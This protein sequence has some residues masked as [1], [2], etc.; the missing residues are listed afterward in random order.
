MKLQTKAPVRRSA[1]RPSRGVDRTLLAT[2]RPAPASR[3][4]PAI[5][6]ARPR[7]V[8]ISRS[9]RQPAPARRSGRL[10]RSA[11]LFGL[12]FAAMD[13]KRHRSAAS[14]HYS[15][16]GLLSASVLLALVLFVP[17]A[18]A[19][20]ATEIQ[21]TEAPPTATGGHDS[22]HSEP[23]AR[24]SHTKGGTTGGE[25]GSKGSNTVKGGSPTEEHSGQGG[26]SATGGEGPGQSGGPN[27]AQGNP[28]KGS[29]HAQATPAKPPSNSTSSSDGGSSPWVPILIAIAALGAISVAVVVAR[30]RR[31]QGDGPGARVSSEPS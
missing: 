31:L 12:T 24:A 15:V 20:E 27:N 18:Q 29:H 9:R 30:R 4:L 25:G 13:G 7:A 26:G 10:V 22:H 16:F 2:R 21:Y 11:P 14:R 5:P 8:P 23:P 3:R 1:P 6:R 28:G 17:Q 19:T